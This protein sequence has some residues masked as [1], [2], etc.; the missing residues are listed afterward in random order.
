MLSN[1][2]QHE[3]LDRWFVE[4]V[5]KHLAGRA[6]LAR[7]ADDAV[8]VFS[9]ERD[10]RR[11]MTV[12]PKRFAK[13]GQSIHPEKTRIVRFAKPKGTGGAPGQPEP[14]VFLGFAHYWGRSRKGRWIVIRKTAANRFTRTLRAIGQWCR[15]HRHL[16]APEQQAALRQKLL[17][18]Y[19]Y[20]GITG[21]GRSL[22]SMLN[23]V[24]RVWHKWLARRGSRFSWERG[25]RLLGRYPLPPARVVHSIYAANL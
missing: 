18:H 13:Y 23:E 24:K 14:F 15:S 10:A 3:V 2:Y 19:G 11:V 20:Y 1:I 25:N 9:E 12:L 7:F 6:F 22:A 21:N 5:Q 16:S 4:V 8:L 17:G